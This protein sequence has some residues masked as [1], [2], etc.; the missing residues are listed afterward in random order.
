[1]NA[2][3]PPNVQKTLDAAVLHLWDKRRPEPDLDSLSEWL[4]GDGWDDVV[5]LSVGCCIYTDRIMDD[6]NDETLLEY[7]DI[8][9]PK[10]I[11]NPQRIEFARSR[12]EHLISDSMDSFHAIP[13]ESK[14]MPPAELCFTMYFHPQGGAYFSG[15]SV[16]HSHQDYLNDCEGDFII[17]ANDLSDSQILTLWKKSEAELK[18]WRKKL[19]K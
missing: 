1:M 18:A 6:L 2:K 9:D 19:F 14:N 7:R 15:I 12:I 8:A 13:I 17:D 5:S 10:K 3:F 11:T 4:E 16:C